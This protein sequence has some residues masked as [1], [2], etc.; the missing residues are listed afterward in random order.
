MFVIPILNTKFTKTKDE[1][2]ARIDPG[3]KGRDLVMQVKQIS[4]LKTRLLLQ[5]VNVR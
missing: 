5:A 2:D 3:T 4:F 1:W